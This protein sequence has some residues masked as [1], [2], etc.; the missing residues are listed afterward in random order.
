MQVQYVENIGWFNMIIDVVK[1]FLGVDY[2]INQLFIENFKN[3][4]NKIEKYIGD[5]SF[6]KFLDIHDM[7]FGFIS[8]EY[9][10]ASG[11]LTR[12]FDSKENLLKFLFSEDSILV[13]GDEFYQDKVIDIY[14]LDR[15]KY[16]DVYRS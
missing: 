12:I 6:D 5:V 11:F 13:V 8:Y 15:F 10:S 14:N 16:F 3:N 9:N 2:F 7:Y 1:E 4:L